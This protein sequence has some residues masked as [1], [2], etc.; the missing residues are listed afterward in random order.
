[1]RA[2][3]QYGLVAINAWMNKERR[4]TIS[5]VLPLVAASLF[6]SWSFLA[7][8]P[9]SVGAQATQPAPAPTPCNS[10]ACITAAVNQAIGT[11]P[12]AGHSVNALGWW[13]PTPQIEQISGNWLPTAQQM[14]QNLYALL[15]VIEFFMVGLQTILF[16]DNLG[17]FFASLTFKIFVASFFF[18]L[19]TDTVD[20]MKIIASFHQASNQISGT[21]MNTLTQF[22]GEVVGVVLIFMAGAAASVAGSAAAE[23]LCPVITGCAVAVQNAAFPITLICSVMALLTFSSLLVVSFTYIML[24]IETSIVMIGGVFMLGF[25]G[26]RFTAPLSQGYMRYAFNVGVKVFAFWLI[27]A[28]EEPLMRGVLADAGLTTATVLLTGIA[29]AIASAGFPGAVGGI[30]I[31]GAVLAVLF[32]AMGAMRVIILNALASSAPTLATSLVNGSTMFSAQETLKGVAASFV[33]AGVTVNAA[34]NLMNKAVQRMGPDSSAGKV[35]ADYGPMY[36]LEPKKHEGTRKDKA[37]KNALEKRD[38]QVKKGLALPVVA[39]PFSAS[40]TTPSVAPEFGSHG[41]VP[42]P[43]VATPQTG[44]VAGGSTP[45]VAAGSTPTVD[46]A[47]QIRVPATASSTISSTRVPPTAVSSASI[48]PT[49]VSPT[50]DHVRLHPPEYDEAPGVAQHLKTMMYDQRRLAVEQEWSDARKDKQSSYGLSG[51]EVEELKGLKLYKFATL[52]AATER[53]SMP[54]HVREWIQEDP[55]RSKLAKRIDREK[56]YEEAAKS[57]TN[58]KSIAFLGALDASTHGARDSGA[59]SLGD[60]GIK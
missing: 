31:G 35:L 24:T 42:V 8:M 32:A 30:A 46:S 25:A 5:R 59:P 22:Y 34:T 57:S 17:E 1:M 3:L 38:L 2:C 43:P 49:G 11:S 13:D 47:I 52:Y 51:L 4:Q 50:G 29:A 26:T 18:F 6:L 58:I 53:S 36:D 48:P 12:G 21:S 27:I 9:L 14:A 20:I 28:I 23:S 19:I 56:R 54:S 44:T 45:N 40:T 37:I 33:E 41:I 16:R 60:S 10:Q 15:F 39:T 7:F 55:V